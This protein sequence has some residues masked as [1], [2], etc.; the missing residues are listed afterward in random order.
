MSK[1]LSKSQ[2]R[3]FKALAEKSFKTCKKLTAYLDEYNEETGL[4][5]DFH[6]FFVEVLM[7]SE[8]DYIKMI[9]YQA[10]T[11][12]KK[13]RRRKA[14]ESPKPRKINQDK[15]VEKGIG[16]TT[17]PEYSKYWEIFTDYN[18]NYLGSTE[19]TGKK[20]LKGYFIWRYG[21][22]ENVALAESKKLSS[23]IFKKKK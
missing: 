13:E 6:V 1:K 11:K 4:H 16:D 3:Y 20:T 14:Q 18:E 19:I 23:I 21:Y 12:A 10:K 15:L 7:Y 9:T 5:I 17:N 8:E 2:K 22:D